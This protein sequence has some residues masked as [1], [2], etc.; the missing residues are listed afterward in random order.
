MQV[1]FS[2]FR[3][4]RTFSLNHQVYFVFRAANSNGSQWDKLSIFTFPFRNIGPIFHPDDTAKVLAFSGGFGTSCNDR[5]AAKLLFAEFR[6][7]LHLHRLETAYE[8][9]DMACLEG[10]ISMS[11]EHLREHIW[12]PSIESLFTSS[13]RYRFRMQSRIHHGR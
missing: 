2:V 10:D 6:S 13:S 4:A 3:D 11:V 1:Q 9:G 7:L 12:V 5:L 8:L